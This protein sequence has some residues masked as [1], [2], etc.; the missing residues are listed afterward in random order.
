MKQFFILLFSVFAFGSLYA[1]QPPFTATYSSH[2]E[3][4]DPK[5][6]QAILMLWKGWDDGDMSAEAVYYADTVTMYLADGNIVHA[7]RDSLIAANKS[8]RNSFI[9]V[10][11]KVHAWV[12]LRST[13][14]KENWVYIWGADKSTD[15]NGKTESTELF[16]TWRFNDKGKADLM[17]EFAAKAPSQH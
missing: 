4:G 8:I 7:S 14:K 15:K 12:A 11:S 6:A 17:Y 5:N 1:Q 13:D 16:E 10:E 9:K 2:F 3:I